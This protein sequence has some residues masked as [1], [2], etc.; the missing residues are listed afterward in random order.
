LRI[1]TISNE[2]ILNIPE[3]T[4]RED[5]KERGGRTREGRVICKEKGDLKVAGKLQTYTV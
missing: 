4:Y 3:T 1:W 5:L 2:Q